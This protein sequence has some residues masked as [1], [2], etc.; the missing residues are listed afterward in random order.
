MKNKELTTLNLICERKMAEDGTLRS[1]SIVLA[2][3]IRKQIEKCYA[4]GCR[5]VEV[6]EIIN[7]HQSAI[8]N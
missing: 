5:V 3:E 6:Q 4:I 7:K 8:I 2:Y 1:K